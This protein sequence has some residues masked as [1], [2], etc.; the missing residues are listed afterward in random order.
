MLIQ[1]C[2][3]AA[4][5]VAEEVTSVA[6]LVAVVGGLGVLGVSDHEGVLV[7]GAGT[8][9]CDLGSTVLGVLLDFG[10]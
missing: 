6:T 9:A 3:A 10:H 4:F 1:I 5:S 2:A 7:L 8:V